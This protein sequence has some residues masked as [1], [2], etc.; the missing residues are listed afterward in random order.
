MNATHAI[1]RVGSIGSVTGWTGAH[2]DDPPSAA[3][4]TIPGA[5][6]IT[7]YQPACFVVSEGEAM[8]PLKIKSN[9]SLKFAAAPSI[10]VKAEENGRVSGYGSTFL[11]V[12]SYSERVMPGAFAKSIQEHK[13]RGS[14]P[15]ML[16]QHDQNK[17]IGKWL[18]IKE[19]GRGLY[20]IGQLNLKTTNGKDAYEH[21]I[22]GDVDG[23][24]IGYREKK[25]APGAV[26]DLLE[27]DLL[28]VSVVTF[29]ANREATADAIKALQSKADLVDMLREGGLS[30][31][32]AQAVAAG[33]WKALSK[34]TDIDGDAASNFAAQ[35]DRATQLLKGI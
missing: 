8:S 35:I 6:H 9:A 33:G 24:S 18:D 4:A 30:K 11:D 29:P 20:V 27:L 19:D 34:A 32:A 21:L 5:K 17:P 15:K 12:D 16:W 14:L 25:V 26:R 10:E 13:N 2:N 23:M 3:Q 31:T 22:A 1:F 28:E 7:G